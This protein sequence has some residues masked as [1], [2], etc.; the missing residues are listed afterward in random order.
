MLGACR[1]RASRL[2]CS[3]T[4][5]VPW[6]LESTPEPF[7]TERLLNHWRNVHSEMRAAVGSAAYER[8]P[9]HFL[10]F[11]GVATA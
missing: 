7:D 8:Q 3:L 11:V 10:A 2:Q 5:L 9:E 1:R 6:K 4:A